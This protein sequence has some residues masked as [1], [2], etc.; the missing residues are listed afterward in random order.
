M[1]V[2]AG[3]GNH[4]GQLRQGTLVVDDLD[5][6][7][8]AEFLFL[9]LVHFPLHRQVLV[10][11]AAV[12]LDV[13]AGLLVN[14]QS[15]AR[16]DVGD[17]GIPRDRTTA[18]R[19]GDQHAVGPLDG[20]LLAAGFRLLFRRQLVTQHAAGHHDAHGIAKAHVGQQAL[21][22]L[23]L[24][25]G[26]HL[27]DA[28]LGDVFDVL[29][30][31][32][33]V[34][35]ATAQHH[36]LFG[37]QVLEELA[38]LGARLGGHH[39]VEPGRVGAGARC[40]D[41]LHRLAR[42]QRTAERI[43][44]TVDPG[45]DA[46][47]ADVGVHRVGEVH[48]GGA[49]G[50]LH[51]AALRSEDVDLVREEVGLDPFDEFKGAAGAL[52]QLQQALHPALGA[53]LGR[54]ARAVAILLVGPVGG[55]ALVG[56]LIHELGAD[57]HLHRHPVRP[58]QG[59]VQG[60]VAIALG[61]GDVVLEAAGAGLVEAVHLPKHPVTGVYVLHPDA[62]GVDIHHLM[63]LQLFLLHLVV[64][65]EQVFLA[66]AD[67]GIYAGLAQATLNLALDGVDDLAAI[68]AG[69]AYRFPQHPGTHGVERLEAQ[70]FQ[71]VLHGVNTE[72]VGDGGED[73]EGFPG[74]AA[75]L[76]RPQ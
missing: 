9:I 44:V 46:G 23:V 16:A 55:D 51:D 58:H 53:D 7:A 36:R 29:G 66:T 39:E 48:R 33:M 22:V 56:H 26:Q 15:L 47:V 72:A 59:G 76:V 24:G 21:Q 41:D 37:A 32:G 8:G 65:G 74:D 75:T 60:L 19:E 34:E 11:L 27:L 2:G 52:L 12:A 38:D 30:A 6:D 57:L 62:E 70:L 69:A 13:A 40:R 18:V 61:N 3:G 67:L 35:Q 50:Q 64:D 43:G 20:H 28:R 73:L 31:E 42:M 63:E 4:V 5:A 1:D 54:G 14:D 49:G 45:A 10:R 25:V 71:L 68:A 17:D